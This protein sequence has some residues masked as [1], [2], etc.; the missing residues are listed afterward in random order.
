MTRLAKTR[1]GTTVYRHPPRLRGLAPR[2][3]GLLVLLVAAPVWAGATAEEKYQSRLAKIGAEDAK[4]HYRLAMW[5]RRHKLPLR[6]EECLKRVLQLDENHEGARRQLGYVRYRGRWVRKE[7][8]ATAEFEDRLSEIADDDSRAVF[9]LAEWANRRKLFAHAETLYRR[10][11]ELDPEHRRAQARLGRVAS[12]LLREQVASYVTGQGQIRA[13]A[14]AT[15]RRRDRIREEEIG[16]WILFVREQLERLGKHDGSEITTLKHEQYPVRYRLLR[17]RKGKALSLLIL[18]H[19]GGPSTR[20]NDMTWANLVRHRSA[21]YDLIAM[22]RAWNDRTGA[23]WILESG[24]VIIEAMIREILR[25]YPVDPNRVYLQ[26]YSMGGY[27][28]SYVGALQADRFAALAVCAAG[29]GGGE[30][31][32]NLLHVPLAVHI[33][34]HDRQSDHI[35]TARKLRDLVLEARKGM[36]GGYQLAYR[37]YPTGHQLPGSAQRDC[38]QWMA[39]FARDPNPRHIVW[40]PF[41]S[42]RYPTY[43]NH[44]Y[45]LHLAEPRNG[46]RVEGHIEGNKITLVT[47]GPVCGLSLLLNSKLVDT[48]KPVVVKKNVKL[49]FKGNVKPSL[50]ALVTSYVA[51]EDPTMI[52]PYRIELR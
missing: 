28:T 33:G 45:W 6:A 21:P 1:Q 47:N 20:I 49:M 43:K 8:L 13:K 44:F 25:T 34:E 9:A 22:P 15:L 51:K 14:L 4:G 39:Q 7:D 2:A 41:T 3:V 26:G 19:S 17:K 30:R 16:G 38:F 37:E 18:L 23:G 35:G 5:C 10:V 12:G 29:H 11:L 48:S 52:Y 24:P 36:P 50:S 40:E 46:V 42:R 32:A 31:P 27:G